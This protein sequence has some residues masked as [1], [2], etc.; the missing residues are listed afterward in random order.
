MVV[1]VCGGGGSHLMV[2]KKQRKR[3]DVA[4]DK[5][6]QGPTATDLFLPARPHLL[7]FPQISK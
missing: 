2:D 5:I 4:R 1:R 3:Q 6:T 7:K